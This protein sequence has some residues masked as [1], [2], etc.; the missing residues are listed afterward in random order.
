[1]TATVVG[2]PPDARPAVQVPD[3]ELPRALEAGSPAE[4]RGGGRD[5][6]R[7]LVTRRSTDLLTH[8]HLRDLPRW[9]E[10][11][12]LLVV[13]V[14]QPLPVAVPVDGAGGDRWVHLATP[15]P[16]GD[17]I[18]EPRRRDGHGTRELAVH[19]PDRWPLAGGGVELLSRHGP[20]DGPPRLWRARL[21]H[22]GALAAWLDRVGQPVRYAYTDRA[23]PLKRYRTVYGTVPGSAESPS[24]GRPL[25]W[26][27][28]GRVREAGVRVAPV[29]LHCGVST[30]PAPLPERFDMPA[31]TARL[32]NA[33]RRRGGRV[34]AVG[35]AAVRA[36]ETA[37]APDGSVRADRGWTDL[38]IGPARPVRA[39]DGLL[40]GW[41]EPDSSH[42]RLLTAF[43]DGDQLATAYRSALR[44]GY[45]WHEFG[46]L[47]L[48]LPSGDGRGARHE[49]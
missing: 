36:V 29:V 48:L 28:L 32:V 23:W 3:F 25:T 9:L 18:V 38:E 34:V 22:P 40:T 8:A 35:T 6:V 13:N 4:V 45:L 43:A 12:D 5:D 31:A 17:W 33:T 39:V 24:A 19:S 41:H 21:S 30:A 16:G 26:N 44:H 15:L 27:L 42:L 47:H 46:D 20:P 11:G 10:P 7:M 1:M 49:A 2:P 14:S 37:A